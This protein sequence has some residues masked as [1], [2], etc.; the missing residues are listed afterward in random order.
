MRSG[1]GK[2]GQALLNFAFSSRKIFT[3]FVLLSS[4]VVGLFTFIPVLAAEA[5][6][7]DESKSGIV[8]DGKAFNRSSGL[9]RSSL[10]DEVKEDNVFTH[11][12][13]RNL[14]SGNQ[15][16]TII[17][18]TDEQMNNDPPTGRI[19]TYEMTPTGGYE[20]IREPE[21]IVVDGVSV[22]ETGCSV[23]GGAGWVICNIGETLSGAM[24]GLYSILQGFLDVQ[25]LTADSNSGLFQIWNYVKNIA[26]VVFAIVL[27]VIVYSQIT[28]I[29]VN[30]YGI[31]KM[32][33]KI[34]VAA[35]LLNLSFYICAI[36]VD[37]SNILGHELQDILINIRKDIFQNPDNLI[38]V[39]ELSWA[40]V[41]SAVLAGAGTIAY[42]GT[43]FFIMG[44]AGVVWL[45]IAS[46]ISVAF[47]AM[48]ALVVLAARQALITV[49]VFLAPLAFLANILPNTEKWFE[50][51]KDT[52][53]TMLI[54]YPIF[55]LLFGGSQL[56]GTAIMTNSNGNI[57]TLILG[58]LVQ[59]VP[60]VLT[61]FIVSFSG[62]LLG[63]FAGMINNPDKGP[64]DKA[65][66]YA[67]DRAGIARAKAVRNS[68]REFT[69]SD[70]QKHYRP[71]RGLRG[72]TARANMLAYSHSTNKKM[73]EEAAEESKKSLYNSSQQDMINSSNSSIREQSAVYQRNVASEISQTSQKG[74][75]S[76]FENHIANLYKDSIKVE[77][78]GTVK[79]DKSSIEALGGSALSLLEARNYR[80][81]YG[82][83]AS[84][85]GFEISKNYHTH[86]NS[87]SNL[88]QAS[89]G[90]RGEIGEQ[91]SLARAM[92]RQQALNETEIKEKRSL[93]ESLNLS[94]QEYQD[95][96]LGDGYKDP[97][98]GW[99][100]TRD[101]TNTLKA[102][103]LPWMQKSD[104][105]DIMYA[106]K[107]TAPGGKFEKTRGSM[108]SAFD[109]SGKKAEVGA[110]GARFMDELGRE[111]K[112][113]QQISQ[114]FFDGIAD[115]LTAEKFLKQKNS[116]QLEIIK[117]IN[118]NNIKNSANIKKVMEDI[119]NNPDLSAKL[120]GQDMVNNFNT[121]VKLTKADKADPKK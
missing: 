108:A 39:D 117:G 119:L 105:I 31:K 76:V 32:L 59:V 91:S 83:A 54:M 118:N 20:A 27:I 21:E 12:S 113:S 28:N 43:S 62:N 98:H 67:M 9:N 34:I 100:F 52:F 5:R 44:G 6:W 10:P 60:L 111:G 80:T 102:A 16:V 75:E 4:L 58:M 68:M 115:N 70:G 45:I 24:D 65:Q 41:T 95:I 57:V 109:E 46:L 66:N 78:D 99:E 38:E 18:M 2:S 87:S 63:K 8:Y 55:A 90:A 112:N 33:P 50:K 53:G 35:I 51:W 101:D 29:G 40:S 11:T 106:L 25:P 17:S 97:N 36:L 107:E 37:L 7:T 61:P 114:A 86:L 82:D 110:F 14:M 69:T 71:Q 26:N 74:L 93:L 84:N 96:V 30:N 56:T 1:L 72:M 23:T 79:I 42:G 94:G 15:T 47:S 121:L 64:F 81:A 19:F 48:V 13:G 77:A 89:A 88:L 104:P 116:V 49:L 85:A 22:T 92:A 73:L 120:D 103:A 3:L